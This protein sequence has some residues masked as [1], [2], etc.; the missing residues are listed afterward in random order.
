MG[1]FW[2]RKA[3][4][5][6]YKPGLEFVSGDEDN[7]EMVS[8]Y[9]LASAG[10]YSLSPG[11]HTRYLLGSPLFSRITL[12]LAGGT[13]LTVRAVNQA[14]TNVYVHKVELNGKPLDTGYV[15]YSDLMQGGELTFYMSPHPKEE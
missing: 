5:E 10:L 12:S 6:L 3:L 13:K 7:G 11:A 1:Q 14:A 8:W 2:L 4:V 9:M 15:E